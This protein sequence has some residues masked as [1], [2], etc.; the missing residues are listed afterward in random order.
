[1]GDRIRRHIGTMVGCGSYQY[2][3][4]EPRNRVPVGLSWNVLGNGGVG[5]FGGNTETS[6]PE[7]NCPWCL[8]FCCRNRRSSRSS[9]ADEVVGLQ[10]PHSQAL[11][12]DASEDAKTG[13]WT[14]SSSSKAV[15]SVSAEGASGAAWGR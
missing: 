14:T 13:A 11:H 15:N 5:H 8:D 12:S 1:M 3:L 4:T 6:T 7:R 9:L 10:T 2:F